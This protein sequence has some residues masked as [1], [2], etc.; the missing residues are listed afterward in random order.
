[1]SLEKP[2][3]KGLEWRLEVLFC[4]LSAASEIG[5]RGTVSLNFEA[6]VQGQSGLSDSF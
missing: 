2:S 1:M 6:S 4:C 5:P 3:K